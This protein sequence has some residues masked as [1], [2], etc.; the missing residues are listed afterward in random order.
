MKR[1]LIPILLTCC[2]MAASSRQ[3]VIAQNKYALLI[4]TGQTVNDNQF[5]HSEYWYD[6]FF[7]YRT[8]IDLGYTHDNI[9]VLYGNGN[10]FNS[11]HAFYNSTTVYPADAPITDFSV[12]ADNVDSIFNWLANGNAAMGVPQLQDNDNLF[13]WWMGHGGGCACADYSAGIETTGESVTDNE[14]LTYFGRLPACMI[15]TE[16]V[17]T[18]RSGGLIDDLEGGHSMIHTAA[19]CCTNA[20]S[21]MYDVPHAELSYHMA[22]ALRKQTPAGAAVASDTDGNGV[23]DIEETNVYTHANTVASVSQIGDYRNIAPQ[24][25]PENAVPAAAVIKTGVYS[26]DHEY[27]NGTTPSNSHVWYHGPDLWN[28][29]AADGIETPQNP[30][31]GQTNYVYGKIHNIGC[32]TLNN[33]TVDFSWCLQSAW[34]NMASWNAIGTSTL[35]GFTPG[36]SRVVHVP[37]STVPA[38]ATYC[39]HTVLNVAGDPANASGIS[40]MDNNKV[41]I[42]VEVVDD[43]WGWVALFPFAIENGLDKEAVVDLQIEK[44]DKLSLTSEIKLELPA[45]IDFRSAKGTKIEESRQGQILQITNEIAIIKGIPLKPRE[46]K[47]AMMTVTLPNRPFIKGGI[48][49]VKVSEM[50]KGEEMGGI[51]FK[52]RNANE[53]KVL[54]ELNKDLINLFKMMSEKF[55]IKT[56]EMLVKELSG[57][58]K[59]KINREN[60]MAA[61]PKVVEL[62][63]EILQELSRKMKRNEVFEFRNALKQT[64]VGI[65]KQNPDLVHESQKRMIFSTIP[66]FMRQ[67]KGSGFE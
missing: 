64:M 16:Y 10:D 44:L 54:S 37:W 9:F 59:E 47:M 45:N 61:I 33:V 50:I 25:I 5:Y 34:N 56:G 4:S 66:L 48:A 1:I 14:F 3:K 19:E 8:L 43:V 18:C 2:I 28:R 6:M 31:F 57:L 26:R 53:I 24:I 13:Y 7:I 42:N 39:L 63:N 15:K 60:F 35:N 40:Y 17:M 27:D 41:Q 55:D 67:V 36:E 30:E 29:L 62:E 46:K 51:I 49:K 21:D 38:P 23:V 11:A 52:T 32:T 20:A 58:D 12:N 65:E 22:C